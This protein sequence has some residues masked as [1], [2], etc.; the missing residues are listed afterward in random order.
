M[1]KVAILQSNYIPWKGYFDMIAAVDEFILFDDVQFT[2]NDW[3]NRNKIKTPNGL[4]WLSIPVGKNINRRICDVTPTNNLWRIKHWKALESNYRR[5]VFFDEIASLIEPFY[6]SQKNTDLSKIN[7]ELIETICN[8]L[9]INTKIKYS[10]EYEP[11]EGKTDRLT[12]LCSQANATEYISGPAAK[13]YLDIKAF[14]R[15]SIKLSWFEY[16]NY[17]E[18]PQLWGQFE[19]NVSILDLLFNCGKKSHK[20][21][22][23]LY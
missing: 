6:S 15:N 13:N 9:N 11:C 1:K 10:W 19:H 22:R 16:N 8:Y 17:L 7:R 4:A 12:S 2:K 20:Y 14:E 23:H 18:Y 21:L 5:S 3:R